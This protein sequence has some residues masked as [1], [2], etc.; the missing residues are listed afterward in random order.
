MDFDR[1]EMD[2]IYIQFMYVENRLSMR[3]AE[4]YKYN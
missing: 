1:V 3:T 2:K 4:F